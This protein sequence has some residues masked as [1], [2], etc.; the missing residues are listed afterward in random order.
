MAIAL[1]LAAAI[2][3]GAADFVGG[4]VTRKTGVLS[5][6]FVA[7]LAGFVFMA[8]ALPVLLADAMTA[9]ARTWGTLAG[10][11]GAFG[12][13]FL[14]RGLARGKMSVVAPITGVIAASIPV[15]FGL[16]TGDRPQTIAMLGIVVALLAVVLVSSSSEGAAE[17]EGVSEKAPLG[18]TEALLAG[19]G[20]GAFFILL[21]E[22]GTAAGL[23]PILWVKVGAMVAVLAFALVTRRSVAPS[24][25]AVK[26]LVAAG[27]L[28]M[29]ANL[30][31]LL[32]TRRGLLSLVVVITSMYPAMTVLM[33]RIVLSERLT[34]TQLGGLSLAALGVVLIALG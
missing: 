13:A 21:D 12:V 31:Y 20:F 23:W 4:L 15:V 33:A 9:D 27:F 6:V 32:A 8:L 19:T 26:G 16:L 30:L 24:K 2:T 34:R 17:V 28:D 7:Q 25:G 10:V 1:A 22:A 14:Y 29:A 3:Y 11:V 5:A 18:V